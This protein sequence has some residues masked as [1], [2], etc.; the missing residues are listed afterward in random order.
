MC[1]DVYTG[2]SLGWFRRYSLWRRGDTLHELLFTGTIKGHR[3]KHHI[4]G[5]PIYNSCL[6]CSTAL[7]VEVRCY[8]SYVRCLVRN[9][10]CNTM[11]HLTADAVLFAH[12]LR[13]APDATPCHTS[14]PQGVIN[15]TLPRSWVLAHV[16]AL[17]LPGLSM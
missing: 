1:R 13:K 16:L 7:Y 14:P 15:T 10:R 2:R 3:I 8:I 12:V 6:L 5:P 11:S 9:A 17:E 4:R